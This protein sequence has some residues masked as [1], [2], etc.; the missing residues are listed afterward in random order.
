MSQQISNW[1]GSKGS[2]KLDPKAMP[3]VITNLD[4]ANLGL[5]TD[6]YWKHK[7]KLEETMLALMISCQM[8]LQL[9]SEWCI[10]FDYYTTMVYSPTMVYPDCDKNI[11]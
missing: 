4:V 7:F 9:L 3:C 5:L 11:V 10:E 1:I 2:C 6:S 8:G